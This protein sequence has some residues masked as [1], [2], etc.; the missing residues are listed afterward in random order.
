MYTHL[1]KVQ[2]PTNLD[3]LHCAVGPTWQR[4]HATKTVRWNQ[5]L[6]AENSMC[7]TFQPS[8]DGMS[9]TDAQQVYIPQI[10][11]FTWMICHRIQNFLFHN[12]YAGC[13]YTTCIIQGSEKGSSITQLPMQQR[14][15]LQFCQTPKEKK[16][17]GI[18]MLLHCYSR[19]QHCI[20]I[21]TS[22]FSVFHHFLMR[23]KRSSLE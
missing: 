15:C 12:F 16:L 1:W 5:C 3:A 2:L 11:A 22:A 4:L 17:S 14:K 9:W 10:D 18:V 21:R 23:L 13:P 19:L 20:W 8:A 6:D 7:A